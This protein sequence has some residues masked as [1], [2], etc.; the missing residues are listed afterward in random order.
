MREKGTLLHCWWECKPVQ[1]LWKQIW[2]L[3]KK[4]NID[5]P[6]D[7]AIPLLGIYPKDCD[8][9]SS[10]GTCTP[11]F[12]AA[13]FTIAKLWKQP[14]CPTTDEWIKKM[15]MELENIILSEVSLAQKTKNRMFSL[16]CGH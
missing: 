8:T 1:L 2:R 4:L 16:L 12:I 3:L 9:G 13:L 6:F 5:L 7:P 14:R 10:R 15:W 11:M